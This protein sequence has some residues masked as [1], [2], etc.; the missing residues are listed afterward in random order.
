MAHKT[1]IGGTAYEIAGGK[2]LVDGTAYNIKN[3]KTLVGGTAY[4]IGW[5]TPIGDLAV[6]SSVF[7]NVNGVATEFLVVHQGLPDPTLYDSSCDGVWLLMKDIL[8]SGPFSTSNSNGFVNNTARNALN[9]RSFLDL[10]DT[11][12]PDIIKSVIVPTY[13]NNGT[14]SMRMKIFLL[15]YTELGCG[16]TLPG[17]HADYLPSEKCEGSVL[18]YFSDGDK[19]KRIALLNGTATGWWTR[20]PEVGT[21]NYAWFISTTGS[22]VYNEGRAQATAYKGVRPALILPPETLVDGNFNV[23]A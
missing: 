7:M 9:G 6:G 10:L 22:C 11:G 20:T 13:H 14:E 17:Y 16:V 19:A 4:E 3:G 5:G 21:T 12:V 8:Y 23:I 15:S 2:T 1:L 18:E